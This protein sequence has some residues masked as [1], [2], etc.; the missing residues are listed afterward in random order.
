MLSG[1]SHSAHRAAS[2][3]SLALL[4]GRHPE[5]GPAGQ[6]RQPQSRRRAWNEPQRATQLMMSGLAAVILLAIFGLSAFVVIADLRRGRDA[7]ATTE[8]PSI[9]LAIGSR[10]L[11]PSPLTLDEIFP[12][13][14]IRLVSGAATYVVGMTHIDTDCDIAATGKLGVTLR[15]HACSQVVRASMTAPYGG[16][17]VTAGIF[18]LVDERGAAQIGER[19]RQL[20]ETGDGTFAAMS[21]GGPGTD[22]TRQPLAQVGW[23]ERGHYLI[24]CVIVRPDGQIVRDDDPYAQRIIGDLVESYLGDQILGKRSTQP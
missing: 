17:G 8:M 21:T 11:D 14:E 5:T 18:N 3:G 12:E 24:Y 7:T 4:V 2:D 22:P 6:H 1:S 13:S 23:R 10:D 9:P 16:Y 15:D 19:A 20:V